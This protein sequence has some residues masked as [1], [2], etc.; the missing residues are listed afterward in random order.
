[1]A[2]EISQVGDFIF[3]P[4]RTNLPMDMVDVD[5]TIRRFKAIYTYQKDHTTE[6]T[7]FTS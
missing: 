1:M 5:L 6:S 3:G 2:R 7:I 4:I